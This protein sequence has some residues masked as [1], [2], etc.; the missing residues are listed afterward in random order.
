MKRGH[1][2]F[3]RTV[4]GSPVSGPGTPGPGHDEHLG[5]QGWQRLLSEF[6]G[7]VFRGRSDFTAGEKQPV[8]T[9]DT[10]PWVLP[11]VNVPVPSSTSSPEG[12]PLAL[13]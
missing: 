1:P 13:V 4:A 5:K 8:L 10:R 11:P 12:R 2:E 7:K 9:L 6:L 3:S